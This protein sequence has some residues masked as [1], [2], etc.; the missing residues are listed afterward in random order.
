M[1]NLKWD[2]TLHP[3][4]HDEIGIAIQSEDGCFVMANHTNGGIGGDK[5]QPSQGDYD[6]WI[7]KFCDTTLTASLTHA[8]SE[9]N[10]TIAPNPASDELSI[11]YAQNDKATIRIMNTLGET[12]LVSEINTQNT[13]LNI[14]SLSNGI[15]FL[16]FN[17]GVQH[18][19]R[20]F[21]VQR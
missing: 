20:K 14:S 7:V 12:L 8:P 10:I 2:K 13:K 1:G 16:Q 19:N 3:T 9:A 6:Y 5:T 4:G 18:F 11:S 15:Y 21:V 17:S